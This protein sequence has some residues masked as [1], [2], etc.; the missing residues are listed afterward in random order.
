VF[1]G[2]G[3]LPEDIPPDD[4]VVPGPATTDERAGPADERMALEADAESEIETMLEDTLRIIAERWAAEP[5]PT[6]A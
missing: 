5:V 3:A 4:F 1:E 2:E 6:T